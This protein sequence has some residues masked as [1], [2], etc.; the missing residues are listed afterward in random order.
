[1]SEPVKDVVA[2]SKEVLR[3]M[4]LTYVSGGRVK[5]AMVGLLDQVER[6]NLLLAKQQKI[7]DDNQYANDWWV[8]CQRLQAE[9]K[10]LNEYIQMI[11][12]VG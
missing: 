9:V 5:T 2:E 3:E 4:A 11:G 12:D 7:N 6:L 8:E 10:S 1:M